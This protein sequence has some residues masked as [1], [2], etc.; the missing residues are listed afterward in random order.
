MWSM[1][2]GSRHRTFHLR[3]RRNK[4]VIEDH[5]DRMYELDATLARAARRR[6]G[7]PGA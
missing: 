2:Q 1:S 3:Y 4:G 5:F 7:N 6:D